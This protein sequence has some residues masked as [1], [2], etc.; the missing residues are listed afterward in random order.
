MGIRAAM[1]CIVIMCHIHTITMTSWW[2]RRRLK[3]PASRLFTQPFIQLRLKKTSKLRVTGLCE[4]NSPVTGEISEQ[5]PSNAENVS[6]LWRHHDILTAVWNYFVLSLMQT[7]WMQRETIGSPC[8]FWC[9]FLAVMKNKLLD[10]HNLYCA[11]VS[12]CDI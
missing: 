2:A 4:K 10:I 1:N 12:K 11:C 3:S 6:I 8:W 7:F 5:R 9:Q